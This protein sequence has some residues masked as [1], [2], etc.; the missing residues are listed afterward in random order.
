MSVADL[1][2]SYEKNV[3]L[4]STAHASPFDQFSSWFDEAVAA[5]VP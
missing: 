3:L 4:E 5:Q 1:R 2:Q